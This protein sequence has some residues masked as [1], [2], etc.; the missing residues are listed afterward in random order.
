MI[1]L[2][3]TVVIADALYKS[4]SPA[5]VVGVSPNTIQVTVKDCNGSVR[6]FYRTEDYVN[7]W[8]EHTS[9]GHGVISGNLIVVDLQSMPQV[10]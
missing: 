4:A 2:G 5:E 1:Q 6:L 9:T 10:N 8:V 3:Q 7:T